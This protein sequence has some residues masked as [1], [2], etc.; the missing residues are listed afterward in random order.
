MAKDGTNRGGAR[1]GAGASAA[2]HSCRRQL[3]G[4]WIVMNLDTADV[5]G[6]EMPE[7]I[8]CLRLYKKTA[9][10]WLQVK[11]TETHGSG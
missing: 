11:S 10:H 2:G 7:L 3:G 9:R 8:K 1:V 4:N 6:L 5:K